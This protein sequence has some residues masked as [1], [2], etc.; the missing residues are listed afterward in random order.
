MNFARKERRYLL[1][2]HG[3]GNLTF[4]DHFA[5]FTDAL[6]TLC[7][8]LVGSKN[9]FGSNG[10]GFNGLSHIALTKAV[11]VADVQGSWPRSSD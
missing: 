9:L 2:G 8:T 11:T 5:H 3:E 1:R 6:G 7:L 10:T 4:L